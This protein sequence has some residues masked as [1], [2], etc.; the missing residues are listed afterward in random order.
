[1]AANANPPVTVVGTR[2]PD[3]LLG[4]MDSLADATRLRLLRLLEEHELGVTELVHILQMPQ[5]TIS[6]H[7]KVL[8]DQGWVTSRA[9]ATT[10]LYRMAESP[11][12][13]ARR[14][15]LWAREQ[16]ESW[17]TVQHD[18]LRLARLL[19]RREP[20]GPAFFA[21]AAAQWDRIRDEMYGRSFSESAV[22][23]LLPP[24][25]VIADLGCGTGSLTASLAPWVGRVIGVDQSAAMLKT[26]RRRT[27]GLDNVELRRGPL[28]GLPLEGASCD[29]ALLVLALAYV[30][31]PAP[32]L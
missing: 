14:L 23:A 24:D 1:M 29:G 32:V 18:A 13:T 28:E 7:L 25:A 31:D 8:A 12:A 20:G 6:R 16:T 27:A 26:A 2:Q 15:W 4:W 10:N 22:A 17:A 21:S 19:A 30:D 3:V 5:S 11:E 9:Q